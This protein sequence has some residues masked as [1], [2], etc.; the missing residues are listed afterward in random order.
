LQRIV[1]K[2]SP[3]SIN[4]V[5]VQSW[6]G[7]KLTNVS[8]MNMNQIYEAPIE[9][10]EPI[11]F[12]SDK[13][14]HAR[15]DSEM[16]P[17][18]ER[19]L[20]IIYGKVN[21]PLNMCAMKMP[22]IEAVEYDRNIVIDTAATVKCL[23]IM[24]S[25]ARKFTL[26]HVNKEMLESRVFFGKKRATVRT[27]GNRQRG[28]RRSPSRTEENRRRGERRS[29]S[30]SDDDSDYDNREGGERRSPSPSDDD[31]DY[32]DREGG[33]RRSPSPSDDDSD[34]EGETESSDE[35]GDEAPY[36]RIS[37]SSEGESSDDDE[38]EGRPS[39]KSSGEFYKRGEMSARSQSL[40]TQG[41]RK[42]LR[43]GT[44][45][46][47]P[48]YKSFRDSVRDLKERESREG[49]REQENSQGNRQRGEMQ[50]ER[51]SSSDEDIGERGGR[52]QSYG[53]RQSDEG[54]RSRDGRSKGRKKSGT[55]QRGL[56]NLKKAVGK[57]ARTVFRR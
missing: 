4:N 52:E 55:V 29:P 7:E 33:E 27:E 24:V 21:N 50:G 8:F 54:E 34:Y 48:A 28:E 31:S 41:T 45:D 44:R 37:E 53:R 16:T 13:Q 32:E 43:I 20:S 9:I 42:S 18:A 30:P 51:S 49:E 15:G 19:W 36:R 46:P 38:Y 3:L 25:A 35:E 23:D 5:R 11:D 39:E 12:C 10:V 26:V 14:N 47:K 6:F 57:T 2:F 22:N 40:E 1:S 56:K 17:T